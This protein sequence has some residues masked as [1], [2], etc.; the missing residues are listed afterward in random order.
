MNKK[1]IFISR[2][3]IFSQFTNKIFFYMSQ[4]SKKFRKF[5]FVKKEKIKKKLTTRLIA[6][7]RHAT[8]K[9]RSTIRTLNWSNSHSSH[10][11][12]PLYE[13]SSAGFDRRNRY[14]RN[15]R[16]GHWWYQYNH[17]RT[18]WRV[19]LIFS[20]LYPRRA[21]RKSNRNI[22]NRPKDRTT[23]AWSFDNRNWYFWQL[24]NPKPAHQPESSSRLPES[25]LA[26]ECDSRPVR[27]EYFRMLS[28]FL[29]RPVGKRHP[30]QTHLEENFLIFFC[31][32]ILRLKRS[33]WV[34]F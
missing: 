11:M 26:S 2:F 17:C 29:F 14:S 23:L 16:P 28:Y 21:F 12:Q 7:Q 31:T 27:P 19:E 33:V 25:T 30:I 4:K 32:I 13:L 18:K 15:D 10:R 24:R 5:L 6:W 20:F 1:T 22:R 3:S 8:K 9:T 34:K